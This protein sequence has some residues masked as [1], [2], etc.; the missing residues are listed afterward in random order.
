[1]GIYDREYMSDS[2]KGSGPLGWSQVTWLMVINAVVY[3][4]QHFLLDD[5]GVFKEWFTLSQ[6]GIFSG[7]LWQ[8][9]T[10]QFCHGDAIH[11]IFNML[12]LFF[13]GRAA[14]QLFGSRLILYVYLIG[15]VIGGLLHLVWGFAFGS[16]ILSG[17][18]ASVLAIAIALLCAMPNQSVSFMFLPI[19]IKAKHIAWF[20]L[21]IN[22]L[23][24]LGG[25]F[26]FSTN[27]T[28][29]VSHLGGLA[30]GFL[31]VKRWWPNMK[32]GSGEK[33]EKASL[34]KR[35]KDK[36]D[37][38]KAEKKKEEAAYLNKKVDAILEKIS[39]EGMQ[40]LSAEEKRI[41]ERSS[42]KLSK[43]LDDRGKH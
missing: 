39:E 24:F 29:Y 18:S 27:N 28:S 4:V 16:G 26:G 22:V 11:L 41:L 31:F 7:K 10:F 20:I 9:I 25:L 35:V 14:E 6:S 32:Y 3:V 12:L 30:V 2:N 15:G 23:G 13:M 21:G 36:V 38:K 42:Q 34:K 5:S 37:E 40:S 33:K 8:L 1:M 43:K 19:Q 17:A